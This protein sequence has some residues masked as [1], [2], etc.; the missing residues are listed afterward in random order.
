[1]PGNRQGF[2]SLVPCLMCEKGGQR[3]SRGVRFADDRLT[4]LGILGL[5]HLWWSRA[6]CE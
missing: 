2:S 6:T 3:V 5:R 1:M 4:L